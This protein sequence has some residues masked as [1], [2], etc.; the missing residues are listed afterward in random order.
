VVP[1]DLLAGPLGS[2]YISAAYTNNGL[3]SNNVYKI[4]STGSLSTI[5]TNVNTVFRLSDG[6]GIGFRD[7]P[8]SG[9]SAVVHVVP[10][11]GCTQIP[12]PPEPLYLGDFTTFSGLYGVDSTAADWIIFSNPNGHR[13]GIW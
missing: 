8:G 12:D 3:T 11:Q 1:G 2:F 13:G 5:C 4:T 10:G 6:T 7:F 9:D